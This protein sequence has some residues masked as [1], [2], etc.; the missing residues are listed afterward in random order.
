M[1]YCIETNRIYHKI[2]GHKYLQDMYGLL[3][4]HIVHDFSKR[5]NIDDNG[6][7]LFEFENNSYELLEF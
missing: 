1:K 4:P 5:L 7:I 2:I 6:K 3:H